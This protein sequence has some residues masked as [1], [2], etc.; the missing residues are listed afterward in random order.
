M[1]SIELKKSVCRI[2][3][4]LVKSDNVISVE[5]MDI[6]ETVANNYNLTDAIKAESYSMPLADAAAYVAIQK[7]QV[8]EKVIKIM[9]NC[10]LRDGEC[11]RE[12]AL[13]ISA[14]EIECS[15]KGRIISM[16]FNNRPILS[17][18]ILF[19]DATYNPKKND[20]DK[21]FEE[22]SRIVEMAGFELIYIPQVARE[23]KEYKKTDD[24]KRLLSIINPTLSESALVS[25]VLS[26][27]DM[28]SRYF[29][30]QVLNGKLQMG[31]NLMRPSWLLRLPNSVVSGKGYANFLCYDVDMENITD[32]LKGFIAELNCRQN[33]YSVIVNR[34]SDRSKD[35]LYGG[36]HKALLDV[37]A[38][39]RIEPW[40]VR[41]YVRAG[42]NPVIDESEP[43]KK[44][45]VEISKGK[46]SYPVMINGREAAFYLL[47]LCGSAS[48]GRGIDF[49]YER[50]KSKKIQAQFV[51]AYHLVSN[52]S[53]KFPDITLSSTFRP[54]KTKVM[55]A[56]EECGVKGE[57]HLFKP[58]KLGKNT[59]YI[60]V[61][62]ENVRIISQEGSTPLLDSSVY[63]EYCKITG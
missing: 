59:Y 38:S 28:D 3:T 60:P 19:V 33:P 23:F 50:E 29:Y 39:E 10:A 31:I 32:Q 11:C 43:G 51:E 25:K 52:R 5:E 24:I 45:T 40:E 54:I 1:A 61:N 9:E 47:L 36:F 21:N 57:L 63:H 37:M 48:P 49:E 46:K 2:L 44:F 30:I 18:Q 20:L 4:D 26:L 53:E 17:T 6:L 58:S 27:Q 34:H 22:I 14:L 15:G 55:K 35:F 56:L 41:V 12:E 8:R 42:G 13:L 16:P 7:P 62:P